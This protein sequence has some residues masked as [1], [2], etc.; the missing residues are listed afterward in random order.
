MVSE[1]EEMSSP[2]SEQWL[3]RAMPL[4]SACAMSRRSLR[5]AVRLMACGSGAGIGDRHFLRREVKNAEG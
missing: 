2:I 5:T 1:P 4:R 3:L